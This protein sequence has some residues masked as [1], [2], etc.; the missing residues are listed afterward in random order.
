[1]NLE[2]GGLIVLGLITVFNAG[3][4]WQTLQE[5]RE[6]RRAADERITRLERFVGCGVKEPV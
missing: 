3:A 2:L 4:S 6:W 1:M 5:L